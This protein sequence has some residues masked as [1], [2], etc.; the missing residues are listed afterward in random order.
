MNYSFN[1]K[2]ENTSW[3][4]NSC[5]DTKIHLIWHLTV[6]TTPCDWTP[7]QDKCSPHPQTVFLYIQSKYPTI[8]PIFSKLPSQVLKHLPHAF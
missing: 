5:S 2:E 7:S 4:A 8:M 3:K 6:L 1:C